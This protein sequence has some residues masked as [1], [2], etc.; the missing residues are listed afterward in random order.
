MPGSTV[1][2]VIVPDD[3]FKSN[4]VPTD[5]F[6]LSVSSVF[7]LIALFFW[8][9]YPNISSPTWVTYLAAGWIVFRLDAHAGRVIKAWKQKRFQKK[10]PGNWCLCFFGVPQGIYTSKDTILVRAEFGGGIRIVG[11]RIDYSIRSHRIVAVEE[12]DCTIRLSP[13]RCLRIDWMTQ[14]GGLNSLFLTEFE[15]WQRMLAENWKMKILAFGELDENLPPDVSW[16]PVKQFEF[17]ALNTVIIGASV[18]LTALVLEYLHYA[19]GL[20]SGSVSHFLWLSGACFLAFAMAFGT[21]LTRHSKEALSKA[22][23]TRMN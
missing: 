1:A 19:Y 16:L 3:M 2:N 17:T 15:E 8:V 12:H 11:E 9:I 22:K 18:L 5:H 6:V 7:I 21:L 10:N 20:F 23:R 14:S 13:Q 4:A